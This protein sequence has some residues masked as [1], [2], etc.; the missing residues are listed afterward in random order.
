MVWLSPVKTVVNL[1][2]YFT[3]VT[4]G[5]GTFFFQT[6]QSFAEVYILDVIWWEVS[7]YRKPNFILQLLPK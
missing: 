7:L 1:V 2:S 4:A 3:E 6:P 5:K